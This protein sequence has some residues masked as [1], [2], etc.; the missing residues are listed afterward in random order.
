MEA[1]LARISSL[2][3]ELVERPTSQGAEQ[4]RL[5]V[6]SCLAAAQGRVASAAEQKKLWEAAASAWVR[7]CFA[8]ETSA[9]LCRSH[10][11][12]TA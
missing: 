10:T 5:A 7:V 9:Q 2:T 1:A 12:P 8:F 11:S 3:K 4:L 6:Q